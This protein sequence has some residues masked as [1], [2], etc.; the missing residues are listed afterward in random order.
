MVSAS[1][2]PLSAAFPRRDVMNDHAGCQRTADVEGAAGDLKEHI[3]WYNRQQREEEEKGDLE[4]LSNKASSEGWGPRSQ[5]V[6]RLG[7]DGGV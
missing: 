5:Q 2:R 4:D 7:Q 1:L 3:H 6:D